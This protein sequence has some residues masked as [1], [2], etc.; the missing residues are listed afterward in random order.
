MLVGAPNSEI[1]YATF[2]VASFGRRAGD[3]A[4][5]TGDGVATLVAAQIVTVG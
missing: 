4:W 2:V 1:V 5:L 3:T